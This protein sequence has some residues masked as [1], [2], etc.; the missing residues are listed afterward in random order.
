MTDDEIKD[1]FT[2]PDC[3]CNGCRWLDEIEDDEFP[4]SHCI[5]NLNHV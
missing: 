1:R 3:P 2:V 5:H 4:C